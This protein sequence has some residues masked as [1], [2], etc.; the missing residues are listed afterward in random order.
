MPSCGFRLKTRCFYVRTYNRSSLV[1]SKTI[2]KFKTSR[3]LKIIKTQFIRVNSNLGRCPFIL[4][5]YLW[6]LLP[7]L[8]LIILSV[9]VQS[10][11]GCGSLC[12][13]D[14]CV[15][16]SVHCDPPSDWFEP[17]AETSYN[18]NFEFSYHMVHFSLILIINLELEEKYSPNWQPY[19]WNM[20]NVRY[21]L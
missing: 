11:A 5:E 13:G 6:C 1:Y 14:W 10:G 7:C 4:D 3:S 2:N 21:L 17:S 20:V 19:H 15:M 12:S 8:E 16:L 18:F 9:S